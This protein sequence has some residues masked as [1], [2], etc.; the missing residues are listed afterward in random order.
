MPS[1]AWPQSL[2]GTPA[3]VVLEKALARDR[4]AHSL[5]LH[6]DDLDTLVL[7][8]HAI[9]DRLLNPPEAAQRR[10]PEQH[11][12]F[13]A[14]RPQGKARI[15]PVGD[16]PN[17]KPGT[18]RDFLPKLYV[19]PSVGAR[20]VAVIYEADRMNPASS[21]A[22]LK[23]LEE[24]PG[25]T[26]ILL[27]TTHP[28]ALLPTI[29]SRCLHFRFATSSTPLGHPDLPVWKSDYQAWL[30]R[31]TEGVAG[32]EA[33]A[34]AIFALY[35]L[36]ARFNAILASATAGIW[37]AQKDKLPP[38]LSGE[39]QEAMAIGIANGI[40]QKLFTEVERATVDFA[41][42]RLTAG[43]DSE[44]GRNVRRALTAAVTELERCSGLL[45]LN[46]K[47]AAVLEEFL[48]ASLRLWTTK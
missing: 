39:E 29:R 18:M 1:A 8:A 34:G 4:L 47:E 28:Y 17:P 23:T 20:K 31:L 2:A 3:V 13:F 24:P 14:L 43:R 12:D 37:D 16:A 9:A 6:G 36:I 19:S 11:P 33:V 5:L 30:G 35:G 48:L 41:N 10:P 25:L 27:L 7:V 32:A 15:I 46:M 45:R 38:D 21:N 40:R 44:A 42:P 22:F 26:T